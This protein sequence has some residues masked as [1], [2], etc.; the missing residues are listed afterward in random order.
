MTPMGAVM[1]D[2]SIRR[3]PT[4]VSRLFASGLRFP[5][6][7]VAMADGSVLVVEVRGGT[8]SRCA[9]D[10]TVSVIANVNPAGH[11]GANGAAVGPDGAVYITNNGGFYWSE[12]GGFA[13]PTNFDTGS[14]LPPDYEGGW[15]NRVDCD[16]GESQVLYRDC[17]GH[18]FTGPNDI[19][20]DSHGGFWF[21]DLGK[22]HERTIDKGGVYYARPDGSKV[23]RKVWPMWTPNGVGLSPDEST[24]YVAESM[25]GRLWAFD[26]T[27]PGV[28]APAERG[29]G[30]RCLANTL[31]HFDSLAVE[32]DGTIVVAAISDGLCVVAADGSDVHYV[33]M[34]DPMTTNVCFGGP[35]MRTAFVTLSGAGQLLEVDW[36]R[37]GLTLNY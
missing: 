2:T 31:G 11:G 26:L 33:S 37:A 22:S 21:T 8:L 14:N 35:D 30:G 19:V 17:D 10:G 6:G 24:L 5:E 25:T 12:R 4:P 7:P 15:I 18:R 16:T 36:P 23:E 29:H 3:L 34:P 13:I 27:S 1:S 20:F 9:H 28:I 32:A